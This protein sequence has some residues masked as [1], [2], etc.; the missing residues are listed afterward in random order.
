MG[1]ASSALSLTWMLQML[2]RDQI[3]LLGSDCHNLT[4]RKPN[5][6]EAVAVIRKHLGEDALKRIRDYQEEIFQYEKAIQ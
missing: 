4:S 5:L 2:R 6:G 1:K 3:Q